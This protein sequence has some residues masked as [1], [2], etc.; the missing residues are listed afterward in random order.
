[1]PY[2]KKALRPHPE[3]APV[4]RKRTKRSKHGGKLKLVGGKQSMPH[5]HLSV[6]S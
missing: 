6:K 4:G 3:D 2:S 5:K 1:M